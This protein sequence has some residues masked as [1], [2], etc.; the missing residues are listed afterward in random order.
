MSNI[1]E[2]EDVIRKIKSLMARTVDNGAG[3]DEAFNAL[4]KASKLMAVYN[5]NIDD[6]FLNNTECLTVKIELEGSNKDSIDFCLINL[7]EFCNCRVWFNKFY[8]NNLKKKLSYNFFGIKEDV[9]MAEYLFNTIRNAM[10]AET[11][12]FKLSKE[13]TNPRIY[14]NNRKSLTTSFQR[15]F[16]HRINEKIKQ[17]ILNNEK[18]EKQESTVNIADKT[19]ETNIILLKKKKVEEEF[20]KIGLNLSKGKRSGNISDSFSFDKGKDAAD[21]FNLNRPIN[22]NRQYM[23]T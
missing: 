7:A 15:G 22:N 18:K 16:I 9:A 4:D 21:S 19:Y 3:E 23:L 20:E 14:T 2:R 10:I 6:V 13:Y 11:E 1:A 17:I 8:D 5:V 12:K